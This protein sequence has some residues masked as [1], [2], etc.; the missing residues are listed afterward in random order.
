MTKRFLKAET[1]TL[2]LCPTEV[3]QNAIDESYQRR[4]SK[5]ERTISALET[6]AGNAV[7]FI[8]QLRRPDL[9]D[10]R[11]DSPLV[12]LVDS[13]LFDA[14]QT[15]VSD[16]HVQPYEDR[17]LVRFRIDGVLFDQHVL[18]RQPQDE[19]LSR[20]KIIGN[21][22]IAEKRLPQDGRASVRIGNRLID[23]RIASLP[24]SFGERIVIRLLTRGHGSLR[25]TTSE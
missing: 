2:F 9:L 14:A 17:C 13:I 20:I 12:K 16:I 18:P 4:Q 11:D 8:G 19:L 25:S 7:E 10:D 24:T 5:T 3:I 15:R 22:N 21:M 1:V 6:T 23:L